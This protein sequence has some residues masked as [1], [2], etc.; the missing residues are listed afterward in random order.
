MIIILFIIYGL[1]GY[2]LEGI[3]N[4]ITMGAIVENELNKPSK[5]MFCYSSIYMIPIFG[6]SGVCISLIYNYVP[7]FQRYIAIPIMMLIG[8][9]IIDLIELGSGMLLNKVLKLSIWDYSNS[10]LNLF[11]QIDLLHSIGWAAITIP[12]CF[13]NDLIRLLAKM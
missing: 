2:C 9:I 13:K 10:K 8:A 4:R 12:I 7:F 6:I 3:F 1:L 5:A 11:G